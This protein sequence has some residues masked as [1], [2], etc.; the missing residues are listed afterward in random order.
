MIT[1]N[2]ACETR[3][4]SVMVGIEYGADI[5]T[6]KQILS[7]AVL[8][9]AGIEAEPKPEILVRE[10]ATSAVNIEVRFWVNSRRLPFLEMTSQVAQAVKES[11]QKAKIQMPNE[12]YTVDLR[13]FP[14]FD[15]DNN[16][17]PSKKGS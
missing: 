17:L 8:K 11:L 6:V 16:S 1:N 14:A 3:R 2:T 12:I 15:G 13:N 4:S 10:L 7:D 9:V 5:A